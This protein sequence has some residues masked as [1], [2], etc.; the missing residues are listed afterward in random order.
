MSWKWEDLADAVRRLELS[1][2]EYVLG[3][4]GSQLAHGDVNWVDD[5][6]LIVTERAWDELVDRGWPW[7][8]EAL[9]HPDIDPRAPRQGRLTATTNAPRGTYRAKPGELISRAERVDGL[10]V[11][12][13]DLLQATNP[14]RFEVVRR[15]LAASSAGLVLVVLAVGYGIQILF[16]AGIQHLAFLTTEVQ[17]TVTDRTSAGECG[18]GGDPPRQQKPQSDLTLTWSQD[19]D[20][21]SAV[22][23]ACDTDLLEGDQT[24]A[25]I[26]P[27]DDVAALYSP[28]LAHL[29]AWIVLLFLGAVM[30]VGGVVMLIS[31]TVK[32]ARA[33]GAG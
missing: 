19:G 9:H 20:E 16:G 11:V 1:P 28:W 17:A 22:H 30:A 32:R 3:A 27:S 5:A 8:T 21:Q 25:W 26:T 6:E 10:P 7:L 31:R 18:G 4:H 14:S 33:D 29:Y 15:H 23:R 2:D 13:P 12:P 24:S